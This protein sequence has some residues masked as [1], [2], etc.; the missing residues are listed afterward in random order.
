MYS[1]AVT[2]VG[3]T[4][5]NAGSD[6][7][8]WST[9]YSLAGTWTPTANAVLLPGDCCFLG[10]WTTAARTSKNHPVYLFSYWHGVYGNTS[11]PADQVDSGQRG[12]FDNYMNSWTSGF[13]DG[14]NT[15]NRAGPN[16]ASA[17]VAISPN[18]HWVTHRDFPR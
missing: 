8:I 10:K 3:A 13:S 16:G 7:P 9:S 6:L 12:V 17:V 15:Y 1:S 2:I 14:T 11:L 4:G 18:P 5:Y